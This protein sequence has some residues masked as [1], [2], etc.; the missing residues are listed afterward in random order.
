[1]G[2]MSLVEGADVTP[3]TQAVA[4]SE[5]TQ[6]LLQGVLSRW[7]EL[8]DKDVKTTNDELVKANLP[9]LSVK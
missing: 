1:M 8:R 3:T 7:N 5:Q 9:A 4:A 6:K 2:L